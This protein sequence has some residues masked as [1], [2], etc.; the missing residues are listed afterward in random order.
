MVRVCR[1]RGV[2][3]AVMAG[4][5]S[6][7]RSRSPGTP[8]LPWPALS[9]TVGWRRR[10]EEATRAN[11]TVLRRQTSNPPSKAPQPPSAQRRPARHAAST[12]RTPRWRRPAKTTR[13][14]VSLGGFY[15]ALSWSGGLG[16]ATGR[17]NHSKPPDQAQ[18]T[19]TA[20]TARAEH[21][22]RDLIR[23][24]T[25]WRAHMPCGGHDRSLWDC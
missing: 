19:T 25:A 24:G 9:V 4:C 22:S 11:R 17:V 14:R 3:I 21:P 16:Q 7:F 2:S 13:N 20:K 1:Q 10:F 18:P 15:R 23:R 8:S 6:S 12:G 5:S